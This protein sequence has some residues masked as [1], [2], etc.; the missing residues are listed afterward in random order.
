MRSAL[1]YCSIWPS[2]YAL[3]QHAG[4][5]PIQ[6]SGASGTRAISSLG[7]PNYLGG[8][9]AI[10]LPLLAIWLFAVFVYDHYTYLIVSRGQVRIRQAHHCNTDRFGKRPAVTKIRIGEVRVPIEI[11]V[12][13]MIDATAIFTA[14][15]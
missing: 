6:W 1:R 10:A 15:P 12:D 3:L 9:L 2:A 5:D 8:Y 11:V 13:G 4:A 14:V 7:S